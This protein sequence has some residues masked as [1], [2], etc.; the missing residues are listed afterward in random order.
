MTTERGLVL[1]DG[2]PRSFEGLAEAR[3]CG[4]DGFV[5][6]MMTVL[7]ITTGAGR[8]FEFIDCG[9]YHRDVRKN[10]MFA[11]DTHTAIAPGFDLRA[12]E[13]IRVNSQLMAFDAKRLI[14]LQVVRRLDDEAPL[15]AMAFLAINVDSVARKVAPFPPEV[16]ARLTEVQAAHARLAPLWYVPGPIVSPVPAGAPK[17]PSP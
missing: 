11:L 4:P 3:W 16:I 2:R 15:V 5:K 12:G 13:P 17:P 9:A 8:W 1:D 6:P 7:A 10:G 14:H